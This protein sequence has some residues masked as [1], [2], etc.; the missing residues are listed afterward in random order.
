MA[1]TS[2]SVHKKKL[3]CF[4]LEYDEGSEHLKIAASDPKDV[5]DWILEINNCRQQALEMVCRQYT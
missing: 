1:S 4:G 5:T 3:Y 2:D